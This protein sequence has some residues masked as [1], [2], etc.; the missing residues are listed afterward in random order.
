MIEHR[1]ERKKATLQVTMT[2]DTDLVLGHFPEGEAV[3]VRK[4]EDALR[5]IKNDLVDVAKILLREGEEGRVKWFDEA[6]GYGFI[7]TRNSEDIFVHHRGIRGDG[8]KTLKPNQRVRFKRREGRTS[9]EAYDV[10]D[11]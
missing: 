11:L 4:L 5:G 3:L 10:E 1:I 9:F 2:L 6:K 8:Y 7:T